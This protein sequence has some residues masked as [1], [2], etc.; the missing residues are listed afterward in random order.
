MNVVVLNMRTYR[1][2]TSTKKRPLSCSVLVV[3][4]VNCIDEMTE[5]ADD[6]I[7]FAYILFVRVP[8]AAIKTEEISGRTF[9]SSDWKPVFEL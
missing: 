1:L 4:S 9:N 7:N 5:P 3:P 6:R 2:L 8:V